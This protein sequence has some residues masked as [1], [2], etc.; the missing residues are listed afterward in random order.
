MNLGHDT[1]LT[2]TPVAPGRALM[3]ANGGSYD[4]IWC[5]RL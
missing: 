4:W 2:A 5:M 3:Y 1:S